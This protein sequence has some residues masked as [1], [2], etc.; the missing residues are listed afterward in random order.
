MVV[1]LRKRHP[2]PMPFRGGK[3]ALLVVLLLVLVLAGANV[4]SAGPTARE[5]AFV[6]AV[7]ATRAANGVGPLSV[8][9]A[10]TRAARHQSRVLLARDVL[11]HGDFAGRLRRFGA[12][13]RMLGENLAWGSAGA[14]DPRSIVQAWMRSPGHRENLLRPGFRRIGLGAVVGEFDGWTG[15]TVVT[16]DF[17]G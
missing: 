6:A 3:A 12:T 7:N 10:L 8:D 1:V 4:A 17:A 11:S 15:A 13:G 14:A 9:D 16:A 2:L 5:Q